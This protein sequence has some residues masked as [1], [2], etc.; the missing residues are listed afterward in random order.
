MRFAGERVEAL[1][2]GG[3]TVV[4]AA[5]DAVILAVPPYAAASLLRGLK[6]PTEFRAI[7]NAH[8]RIEPP[9][10]LP[11]ILGVLN[12]T[13]QW[14]FAFPGRLSVTISAGDRLIDV[15]REELAKAIWSEVARVTG[16]PADAAAVADRARAARDVRRHAGAGRE[17]P[18]RRNPMAQSAFWPAIGQIPACPLPSKARSDPAT[19]PLR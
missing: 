4:L 9:P 8:F 14:I 18:R 10:G 2:F 17:A 13:V 7:V 19:A 3:E 5:D 11:P 1:E 12:A 16:L 6:V 15:P